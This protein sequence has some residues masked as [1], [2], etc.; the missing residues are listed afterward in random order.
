MTAFV[1]ERN[2]KPKPTSSRQ[3]QASSTAT[4]AATPGQAATLVAGTAHQRHLPDRSCHAGSDRTAS[5]THTDRGQ[6]QVGESGDHDG[7]PQSEEPWL[8]HQR[9]S[10]LVIGG[11]RSTR[12]TVVPGAWRQTSMAADPRPPGWTRPAPVVRSVH[13]PGYRHTAGQPT[14]PQRLVPET[15]ETR[16]RSVT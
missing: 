10:L 1:S 14:G 9:P 11:H 16:N 13:N 4:V 12:R 7:H 6:H 5:A 3:T 8:V 15:P 2:M